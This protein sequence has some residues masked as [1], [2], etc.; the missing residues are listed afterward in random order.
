MLRGFTQISID[1]YPAIGI[2]DGFCS[3][4]VADDGVQ[5]QLDYFIEPKD[6]EDEQI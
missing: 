2:E 4:I 5:R 3:I 1:A 6:D